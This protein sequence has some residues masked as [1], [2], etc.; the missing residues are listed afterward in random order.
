MYERA[1]QLYTVQQIRDEF[2]IIALTA[3]VATAFIWVF[4]SMNLLSTAVVY[5]GFLVFISLIYAAVD[6]F[7]HDAAEIENNR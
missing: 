3:L 4:V 7:G 1:N 6:Y 5:F 2:R